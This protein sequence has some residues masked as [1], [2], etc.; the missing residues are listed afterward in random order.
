MREKSEATKLNR[1]SK[2]HSSVYSQPDISWIVKHLVERRIKSTKQSSFQ[3]FLK[4]ETTADVSIQRELFQKIFLEQLLK[5][6][7][8]IKLKRHYF[9]YLKKSKIIFLLKKK[10]KRKREKKKK[11]KKEIFSFVHS[12]ASKWKFEWLYWGKALGPKW[13]IETGASA[14][15]SVF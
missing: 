10:K 3:L 11:R 1:L 6:T 4:T 15:I 5:I 12:N 7:V 14:G 9:I 2:F 13:K 8:S